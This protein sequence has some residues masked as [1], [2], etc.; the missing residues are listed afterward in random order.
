[1]I[2]LS[3]LSIN[4]F[5]SVGPEVV[6]SLKD[7]G[8]IGVF[9]AN[10]DTNAADSNGSGKSAIFS[11]AIAWVLY[12]QTLRGISS[13]D[14]V[15]LDKGNNCV[16]SLTIEEDISVYE[17][18]RTRKLTKTKKANDTLVYLNGQNIT[19]GTNQDT[20]ILIDDIIGMDFNTFVQSV[21]LSYGTTPFS[22]MTDKEKNEVFEN[23]LELDKLP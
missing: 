9:G 18:I 8:V 21:L 2:T 23:I 4:N 6:V 17:I 5:L 19:R 22:Q 1:L 15:N 16:V 14:V 20:Q 11:E 13:D 10:K 7:R 12:G 3:K